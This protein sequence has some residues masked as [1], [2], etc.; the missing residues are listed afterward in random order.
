MSL[1]VIYLNILKESIIINHHRI[2]NLKQKRQFEGIYVHE[3]QTKSISNIINVL[4][5]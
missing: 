2:F 5:I 3:S 4:K 1:L